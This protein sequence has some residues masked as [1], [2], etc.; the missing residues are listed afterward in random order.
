[1]H[2]SDDSVAD[3]FSMKGQWFIIYAVWSGCH[4]PELHS[5][6]SAFLSGFQVEKSLPKLQRLSFWDPVYCQCFCK[7]DCVD[8]LVHSEDTFQIAGLPS[9][10]AIVADTFFFIY[11]F[12]FYSLRCTK[13]SLLRTFFHLFFFL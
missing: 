1:M 5:A 8:T 13:K 11:L 2:H 7:T 4:S 3:D 6:R 12:F 9:M 10:H